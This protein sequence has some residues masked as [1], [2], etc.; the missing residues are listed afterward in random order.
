[1]TTEEYFEVIEGLDNN[2]NSY[3]LIPFD[4]ENFK[5]NPYYYTSPL[6]YDPLS[7]KFDELYNVKIKRHDL[8]ADYYLLS[9]L[10]SENFI[11][12]L[13]E[14]DIKYRSIPLNITL[15]RNKIPEKKYFLIYIAD[16]VSILNEDLSTFKLMQDKYSGEIIIENGFKQYDEITKFL[17]NKE[18][19]DG[20]H[21]FY[22]SDINKLV[23][24]KTFKNK[25]IESG[26]KGIDFKKIDNTYKYYSVDPALLK[27]L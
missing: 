12:L 21:L 25:F 5:I 4:F 13:N 19:V 9:N 23:C 26:L 22:C 15:N 24:S 17:V 7:Y 6:E 1:M 10:G 11:Q 2:G 3:Y 27:F 20:Y 18:K 14:L 8:N 16:I